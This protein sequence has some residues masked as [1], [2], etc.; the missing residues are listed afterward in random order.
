MSKCN[1]CAIFPFVS[2][3]QI[4]K[5]TATNHTVEINKQVNCQTKNILYCIACEK[6]TVQYIGETEHS[7]QYRFSEHKGYAINQNTNKT[8]GEHFSQQG[9]RVSNMRVTISEK[10]FGSDLA[11]R[12]QRDGYLIVKMKTKSKGFEIYYFLAKYF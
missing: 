7:L 6:C 8:T 12:K 4:A 11:I 5:S 1:N 10:I 9:H 3:G 2:K